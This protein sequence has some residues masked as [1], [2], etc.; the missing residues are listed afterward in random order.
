MERFDGESGDILIVDDHPHARGSAVDCASPKWMD[1]DGCQQ[2]D[3]RT[4][5]RPA[6]P[7]Q[8]I[9][10]DLMMPMVDGSPFLHELRSPPGCTG[11]P[12]VVL[13]AGI[14]MRSISNA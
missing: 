8:L 13:S 11:S 14:S 9:L 5:H 4:R 10:L 6:Y 12:V 2:R 3:G 7:P 1:Y